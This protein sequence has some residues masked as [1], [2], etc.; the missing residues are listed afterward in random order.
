MIE[1]ANPVA[2][3]LVN[4]SSMHANVFTVEKYQS[5]REVVGNVGLGI[6]LMRWRHC[7]HSSSNASMV[8]LALMF[9]GYNA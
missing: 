2:D 6:N 8:A 5:H 9:K 3:S 4:L 7:T 1:F